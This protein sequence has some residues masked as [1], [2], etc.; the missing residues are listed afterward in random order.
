M[1]SEIAG[2]ALLGPLLVTDLRAPV[3]DRV[4]CTDAS[5][6]AAAVVHAVLPEH[7]ARE[8]WRH[9]DSR[10]SYVRLS[11]K[12]QTADGLYIEDSKESEDLPQS[13]M[14]AFING[15]P[16]AGE[17]CERYC[18]L[19]AVGDSKC[20]RTEPYAPPS[21]QAWFSEIVDSLSFEIDLCYP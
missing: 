9:R 16:R 2:L 5:P 14:E 20:I 15:D 4:W 17:L 21:R 10:G 12:E 13:A 7:A 19:D 6:S 1:R 3:A 11:S 18:Q 8:L